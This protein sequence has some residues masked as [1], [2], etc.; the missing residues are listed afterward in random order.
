M[1]E[2]FLRTDSMI[3]SRYFYF[4]FA[5]SFLEFENKTDIVHL[6]IEWSYSD[7]REKVAT[8]AYSTETYYRIQHKFTESGPHIL[9]K[10]WLVNALRLI[11]NYRIQ[12]KFTKSW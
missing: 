9:G 6:N 12:H 4:F 2:R 1:A 11:N 3:S 10:S 8:T 7:H 5:S